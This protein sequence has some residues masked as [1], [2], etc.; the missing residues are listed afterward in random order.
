MS[1]PGDTLY[2]MTTDRVGLSGPG[3]P[4]VDIG[5]HKYG[6]ARVRFSRCPCCGTAYPHATQANVA[7]P[8][9]GCDYAETPGPMCNGKQITTCGCRLQQVLPSVVAFG[10]SHDEV[11]HS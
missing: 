4:L 5:Y 2:R 1:K 11:F 6:L 10:A 3:T 9:L 8:W 7:F